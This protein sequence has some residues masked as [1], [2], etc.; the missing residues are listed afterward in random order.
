MI[1]E[2]AAEVMNSAACFFMSILII[3]AV[4]KKM[5]DLLHTTNYF[6]IAGADLHQPE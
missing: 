1:T 5:T 4:Y 6:F 2:R 3:S